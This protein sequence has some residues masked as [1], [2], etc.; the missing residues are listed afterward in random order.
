[1]YMRSIT[2]KAL[3]ILP[4]LMLFLLDSSPVFSLQ[5]LQLTDNADSYPISNFIEILEDRSRGATLDEVAGRNDWRGGQTALPNFGLSRSAY[6]ARIMIDNTSSRKSWL[7]E[8]CFP[9]LDHMDVFLKPQAG[10]YT[11]KRSGDCLPFAWREVKHRNIVFDLPGRGKTLLLMRFQ[12][13]GTMSF[14]MT[15]WSAAGFRAK[16]YEEQ[17]VLGVY[18]GIILSLFLYN[19]FLFF[20]LRDRS[21]LYYTLYI[22]CFLMFQT[23]ENGLAFQ[24]LWPGSPWWA[25]RASPFFLGLTALFALVFTRSFIASY[26]YSRIMNV[27]LIA[28]T[29]AGALFICASVLAP[30]HEVIKVGVIMTFIVILIVMLAAIVSLVRGYRPARFFLIAWAILIFFSTLGNAEVAGYLRTN[31]FLLHGVRLG[32]SIEAILLSL[33]LADRI[34]ELRRESERNRIEMLESSHKI[35]LFNEQLD[36]ARKIQQSVIPLSP[37]VVCGLDIAHRYVP[38]EMVG[39]DFYDFHNLGNRRIGI[40]MADVF[41]HG[42]PAALIAS[43]LKIAFSLEKPSAGDPVDVLSNINRTLIGKFRHS[44]L[45]ACYSYIDLESQ[46]LTHASA[47][48]V[49]VIIIKK[50]NSRILK[51]KPRGRLMG[52]VPDIGCAPEAISIEEG[53]RLIYCTDGVTECRNGDGAF[54][55]D[56]ELDDFI[57]SHQSISASEFSDSLLK[58]LE[59]WKGWGS[60]F[61][62]DI[63]LIVVDIV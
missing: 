43:M 37:P 41:G 24:Y 42:V 16:D 55:G 44:Y 2:M 10:A 20:T 8:M 4:T 9:T 49:P 52:L 1:M 62:D 60:G 34:N 25:Q 26:R 61:D 63:S 31:F 17:I 23:A 33:A 13:E 48:H 14:P 3:L 7:L 45:T 11:V 12:T 54:F 27:C 18:Y 15:I 22:F 36:I 6:W 19:L 35:S 47:G 28:A 38:M 50:D 51:L 53:D 29:A 56:G 46:T 57:L 39:G 59:F 40:L 58:Y 5:T 30:Y 32:T 21:Y